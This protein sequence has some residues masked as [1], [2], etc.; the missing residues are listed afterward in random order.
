[1]TAEPLDRWVAPGPIV[2]TRRGAVPVDEIRPDDRVACWVGGHLA[3]RAVLETVIRAPEPALRVKTRRRSVVVPR[4]WSLLRLHR[5][6]QAA[7]WGERPWVSAW[8][9]VVE[10]GRGDPIVL[11]DDA[12]MDGIA[13]VV[14][15]VGYRGVLAALPDTRFAAERVLAVQPAGLL[16]LTELCLDEADNYIADGAVVS[17]GIRH[18]PVA[19][20]E[21]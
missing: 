5:A 19:L 14:S 15:A 16:A 17:S 18:R 2:T 11:I 6:E 12:A 13:P 4:D 20:I 1:M 9:P 3:W 7:P 10:L 21:R 8:A